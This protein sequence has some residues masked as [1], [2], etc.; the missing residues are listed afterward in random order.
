MGMVG[1]SLPTE[2]SS[3]VNHIS[4]KVLTDRR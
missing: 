3:Q 4:E 2:I 1:R